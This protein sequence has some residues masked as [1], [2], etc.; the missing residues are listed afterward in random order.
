MKCAKAVER[1][2]FGL[3]EFGGFLREA[4]VG[5]ARLPRVGGARRRVQIAQPITRRRGVAVAA[6]RA[7]RQRG[8]KRVAE[9]GVVDESRLLPN[10][11]S[12]E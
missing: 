7:E 9:A 3:E 4:L 10:E 8:A 11:L 2:A 5:L 12:A 1:R 6:R